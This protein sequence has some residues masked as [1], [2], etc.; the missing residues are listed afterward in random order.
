[1][2]FAFAAAPAL[3]QT[4]TISGGVIPGAD[5]VVKYSANRRHDVVGHQFGRRLLV[6]GVQTGTYMFTVTLLGFKTFVA[7]DV[8]L[9]TGTAESVAAV[10][11]GGGVAKAVSV[12]SS[13]EGLACS[14]LLPDIPC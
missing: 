5:V 3:A 12:A 2:F 7:S 10:L 9:P 8:V 13:S 11:E 6:P 1:M 4:S 14:G